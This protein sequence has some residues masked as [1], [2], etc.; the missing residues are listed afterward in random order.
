MLFWLDSE[1]EDGDQEMMDNDNDNEVDV[2]NN[3]K[4]DQEDLSEPNRSASFSFCEEFDEVSILLNP[5]VSYL[6][7]ARCTGKAYSCNPS[8]L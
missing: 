5:F 3:H 1:F 8:S 4:E 2:D 7:S 6:E